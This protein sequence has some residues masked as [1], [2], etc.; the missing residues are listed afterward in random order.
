MTEDR[1]LW[2]K[3]LAADLGLFNVAVFFFAWLPPS[4]LK[5]QEQLIMV[6]AVFAAI[7]V[8]THAMRRVRLPGEQWAYLVTAM[9]GALTLLIYAHLAVDPYSVKVPYCLFLLSGVVSGL[10]AHV[11]DGGPGH[12]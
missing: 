7:G 6:G 5:V 2:R 4:T 12:G 1:R 9:V 8:G 3:V 11:I 10:A